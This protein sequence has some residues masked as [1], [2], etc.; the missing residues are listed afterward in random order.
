MIHSINPLVKAK[1]KL[2]AIALESVFTGSYIHR[3]PAKKCQFDRRRHPNWPLWQAGQEDFAQR[4][5]RTQRRK[6]VLSIFVSA[7]SALS[8]MRSSSGCGQS[9]RWTRSCIACRPFVGLCNVLAAGPKDAVLTD[10]T[11]KPPGRLRP[12]RGTRPP[13]WPLLA[14]SPRREDC[15][16]AVMADRASD[17]DSGRGGPLLS[18]K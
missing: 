15:L 6:R 12:E 9:S 5:Q 8:A 14:K 7:T 13:P 1:C 18:S 17:H 10:K 11:K 16:A 3:H 4:S 2:H